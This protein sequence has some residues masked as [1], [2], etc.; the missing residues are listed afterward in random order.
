[1]VTTTLIVFQA[2]KRKT[3]E[4][5]AFSFKRPSTLNESVKVITGS[6]CSTLVSECYM[7]SF[8]EISPQVP[9]KKFTGSHLGHNTGIMVKYLGFPAYNASYKI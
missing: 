2:N 9:E 5:L 8:I 3:H 4:F 7:V 1:M 6:H